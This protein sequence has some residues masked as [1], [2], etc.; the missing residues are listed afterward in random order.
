MATARQGE[1]SIHVED[2]GPLTVLQILG[3]TVEQLRHELQARNLTPL[4]TAKPERQQTLL[5]AV[6]PLPRI[7]LLRSLQPQAMPLGW[8]LDLEPLQVTATVLLNF[9]SSSDD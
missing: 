5:A 9:S 2:P 6:T 8:A 3:M 7:S 4:G 1:V